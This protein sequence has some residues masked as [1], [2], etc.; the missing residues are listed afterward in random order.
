MLRCDNEVGRTW[1]DFGHNF[2]V[3]R[4]RRMDLWWAILSVLAPV[5][6]VALLGTTVLYALSRKSSH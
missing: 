6:F 4:E 3:N 5:V 2:E 1:L